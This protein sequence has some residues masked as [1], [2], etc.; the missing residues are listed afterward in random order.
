MCHLPPHTNA[1]FPGASLPAPVPQGHSRIHPGTGVHSSA[2]ARPRAAACWAFLI[3]YILSKLQSPR[4]TAHG[5]TLCRNSSQP[6]SHP[7]RAES[8]W[9]A[10]PGVVWGGGVPAIGIPGASGEMTSGG[11]HLRAPSSSSVPT[12]SWSWTPNLCSQM[13]IPCRLC[14]CPGLT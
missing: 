2:R 5:Q 8:Q 11:G 14:T 12:S 13:M 7:R 10:G 6:R 3:Q 1:H 4:N 9:R